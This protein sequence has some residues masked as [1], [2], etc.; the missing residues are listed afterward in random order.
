MVL[1]LIYWLNGRQQGVSPPYP[2]HCSLTLTQLFMVRPGPP[3]PVSG[4]FRFKSNRQL[5]GEGL[6]QLCCADVTNESTTYW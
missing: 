6:S 4:S 2:F 3:Q 5:T 1:V